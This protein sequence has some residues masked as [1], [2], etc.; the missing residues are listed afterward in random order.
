MNTRLYVVY[1]TVADEFSPPF[2][3]K[4]HAVAQRKFED[5]IKDFKYRS[6]YELYCV[7]ALQN[8]SGHPSALIIEPCDHLVMSGDDFDG[9]SLDKIPDVS[10]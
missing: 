1:D 4:N 6:D 3:A 8:R 9:K 5:L 2:E 10:P 7:A